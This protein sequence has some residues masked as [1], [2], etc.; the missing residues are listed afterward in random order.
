M[1]IALVCSGVGRVHRGYERF[2]AD[3]YEL[4]E[5]DIDITLFKGG[6]RASRNEI[7]IPSLS[8]DGWLARVPAIATSSIRSP[9]HY[10]CMSFAV[11]LIFHL[12]RSRFDIVHYIDPPLG[13][14]LWHF[15]RIFRLHF[16]M[17]YA[18]AV[19]M[20]PEHY[21]RADHVQHWTVLQY[22]EAIEFGLDAENM[23]VA[24][25]GVHFDSFRNRQEKQVL[26]SKYDLPQDK[27]IVLAVAAVNRHH[28]RIDYLIHEMASLG[29]SCFLLVVGHVED[30]SLFDLAD[31]LLGGDCRFSYVAPQSIRDL[32]SLADVFVLTSL[33]EGFGIAVVE[34]MCAELPVIAHQSPHFQWLV[35]DQQCLVD[36]RVQGA[37]ASRITD[38]CNDK[39]L[40]VK[41][42]ERNATSA[43][44]RFDWFRQKN[45]YMRMYQQAAHNR[46]PDA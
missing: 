8:R 46:S 20:S 29:S 9:Y 4:L 18:N 2:V 23:T 1:K 16:N 7:V 37:L 28:K 39:G 34:A 45:Q 38:L 13:N 11:G 33:E 19:G 43:R 21:Q 5:E 22:E 17:L 36:M 3:L 25:P 12:L 30:R 24:P 41:I 15:R 40:S 32:Y 6:G 14:Y 42:R 10:E 26:R 27:H 44:K 35:G 31:E